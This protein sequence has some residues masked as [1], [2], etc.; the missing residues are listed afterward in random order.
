METCRKMPRKPGDHE[1]EV[2]IGYPWFCLI[3]RSD[4]ITLVSKLNVS[5]VMWLHDNCR[6]WMFRRRRF[7][8]DGEWKL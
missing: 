1:I 8:D 3:T 7:L 2:D 4:N 5:E 6:E